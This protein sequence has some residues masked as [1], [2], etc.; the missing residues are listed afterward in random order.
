MRNL[1]LPKTE[2]KALEKRARDSLALLR[3][4]ATQEERETIDELQMTLFQVTEFA[5]RAQKRIE[6]VEQDAQQMIDMAGIGLMVEMVAHELART[7]ED[8][9]DNLNALR[10]KSVPDDVRSRIESLR[11]S[12]NSISKKTAH[13]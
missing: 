7:S 9:L 6:E 3:E 8:A 11:A 2:V 13:S 12:M 5:Q 10:A 1:S 4:T